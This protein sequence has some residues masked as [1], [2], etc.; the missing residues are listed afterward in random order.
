MGGSIEFQNER[1][2]TGE[3][4]ADIR[5]RH[6]VLRAVDVPSTRASTMIDEYPILAVAAAAASGRTVM[7]GL[8]ELRVKESDRLASTYNMLRCCGAKVS[9]EPDG[10]AVESNGDLLDG[11]TC[12][13]TQMDHRIAMAALVAGMISRSPVQIDHDEMINTS[14]PGFIELANSL[15]ARIKPILS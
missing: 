11:G 2:E 1:L 14:F 3:P 5:V 8:E 6:S 7:R 13:T 9:L 4:V 12:V 10:L 15:G